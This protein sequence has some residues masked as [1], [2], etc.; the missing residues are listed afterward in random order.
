MHLGAQPKKSA[1]AHNQWAPAH[2]IDMGTRA[3]ACQQFFVDMQLHDM[4]FER[5]RA[6]VL[7][8]GTEIVHDALHLHRTL[9]HPRWRDRLRLHRSEPCN[10][11]FV[12]FILVAPLTL[13][14]RYRILAG[15]KCQA[16]DMTHQL[17]RRQVDNALA[18]A[19]EV[20]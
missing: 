5:V 19:Y 17:F 12:R 14:V 15:S 1:E 4:H 20:I 2:R 18:R 7:A 16:I 13:L 10:A 11:K 8:E 6:D 9:A 3:V